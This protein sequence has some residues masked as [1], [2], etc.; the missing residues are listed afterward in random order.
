M[1]KCYIT[2]DLCYGD[3]GKGTIVDFLSRQ[4]EGSLIVRYNGGAQAAHNVITPDGRHHTFS[5]FGSGTL[6]PTTTTFL[7]KYMIVNP[8][9]LITE[10]EGLKKIGCKDALARL[11]IAQEALVTT[12]FH[13]AAN[14]IKEGIYAEHLSGSC[15]MGIWETVSDAEKLN[16]P[17]RISDLASDETIHAKL[18]FIQEMKRIETSNLIKDKVFKDPEIMYQ[19]S[20]LQEAKMLEA[21]EEAFKKFYE[22]VKPVSSYKFTELIN[23]SSQV[24]FEGAQGVLLDK[25]FGFAPYTT[26]TN[27][28]TEN[29][30]AL[31]AGYCQEDLDVNTIGIFRTYFHRHGKGPFVSEDASLRLP[32]EH[33]DNNR[34]QKDFRVGNF[35]TVAAEYAIKTAGTIDSLAITHMDYIPRL[36]QEICWAYTY[37]GKDQDILANYFIL[38][39]YGKEVIG[40][41]V[42]DSEDERE[43]QARMLFDM[44]PV[45][46]RA[47]GIE[48]FED[49][50]AN[51]LHLPVSILSS[52]PTATD[53]KFVGAFSET[54][55]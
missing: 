55:H 52:G 31:L 14:R 54:V 50:I 48:P 25:K 7:S 37:V 42:V 5:Q 18:K 19:I 49:F 43:Q 47:V 13:V 12:P 6:F 29:A 15:G 33:N 45:F 51:C 10:N 30:K 2:V 23:K 8:L 16:F 1:K 9:A 4:A 17:I 11:T 39:R 20:V 36:N 22:L 32:E 53:K 41:K 26:W 40:I 35:D 21:T 46:G 27:I 44:M 3:A 28:T 38:D 34:W 24:I